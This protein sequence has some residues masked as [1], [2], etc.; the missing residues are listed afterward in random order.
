MLPTL[1]AAEALV[2]RTQG[3][4]DTYKI[5]LELFT[6][7][8]WSAIKRIREAGAANIFL[9]LKLHDIPRTVHR[10]ILAMENRGADFLTIHLGGGRKMLEESQKA[11]SK[12]DLH[13]LG[14]SVLTS[15]DGHDLVE[16]GLT[17]DV[18]QNITTR[19]RLARAVF[20]RGVESRVMM[21]KS[22]VSQSLLLCNA[23]HSL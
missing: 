6:A 12:V 17:A 21:I 22:E 2:D 9:D 10:S 3:V 1:E 18:Q 16:I 15:L 5:G 4:F 23:G 14:V 11:A 7:C 20:W 8:G 13:L 19:C